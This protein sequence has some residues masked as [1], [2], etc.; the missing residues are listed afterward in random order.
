MNLIAR[1]LGRLALGASLA[2]ALAAPAPAQTTVAAQTPTA[3]PKQP[4]PP[5][6]PPAP[7]PQTP[8]KPGARGVPAPKGKAAK[9][10]PETR[11]R[12]VLNGTLGFTTQSYDDVRTPIVY[13]EPASI[14]TSYE[15]GVGFGFDAALQGNFYRGFGALVGFSFVSR[16]TDGTVDVSLPH[17]LYLNRPRSVSAEIS[18]YG[19]TE[20]SADLDLAYARTAGKL[21]WAVFAGVTLFRV[22]ADLLSTPT[23]D[24]RYP[25]DELTITATPAAAS[26]ATRSASTSA[27]GSTTAWVSRSAWA[28]SCATRRRASTW[29]RARTRAT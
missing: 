17:P 8:A 20:S 11:F 22:E 28:C 16:D 2:L 1:R 13:A 3:P 27:D 15:T 14:R 18:G 12:L 29:P 10:P 4:A 25:Y 5:P 7:P 21:D 9:R 24:E 26:K 6:K 19:Y 23:F